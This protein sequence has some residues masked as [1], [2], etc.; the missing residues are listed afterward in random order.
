MS[1]Y[2]NLAIGFIVFIVW[3]V[4]GALWAWL[5]GGAAK[6]GGLE[7]KRNSLKDEKSR[8]CDPASNPCQPRERN[9]RI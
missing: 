1:D 4:A 2:R 9:T 5:W 3:L 7:D 6:L 8:A